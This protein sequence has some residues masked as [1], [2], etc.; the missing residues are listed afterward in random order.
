MSLK[1][2][3]EEKE[4]KKLSMQLRKQISLQEAPEWKELLHLVY[5][6]KK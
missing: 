3:K 6:Q 5:E 4:L 2:S 1:S